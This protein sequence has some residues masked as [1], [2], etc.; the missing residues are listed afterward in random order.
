MI[1]IYIGLKTILNELHSN[2]KAMISIWNELKMVFQWR[3]NSLKYINNDLTMMKNHFQRGAN[4]S[5]AF[6]DRKNKQEIKNPYCM[7]CL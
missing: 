3:A 6:A 5:Q 1:S 4:R 7:K 2:F